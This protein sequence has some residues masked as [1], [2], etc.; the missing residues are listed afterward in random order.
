MRGYRNY[1]LN[2]SRTLHN[3]Y[4]ENYNAYHMMRVKQKPTN[5]QKQF[6]E[7]LTKLLTNNNIKPVAQANGDRYTYAIV[8]KRLL[9]Q[10]R[11]HNINTKYNS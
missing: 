5:A 11:E 2:H 8:I 10:C 6:I 1:K 4:D 3:L 7:H 9:S